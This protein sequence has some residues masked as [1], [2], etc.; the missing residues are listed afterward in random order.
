MSDEQRWKAKYLESLEQQEVFEHRWEKRLDLLRR[1]LVRSSLAAEGTDKAVDQCM[2]ELRN[3]VR[4]DDMDAALSALI[5]RLE[6]AVLDSEQRREQRAEQISQSLSALASRLQQLPLPREVNKPLKSYVRQLSSGAVHSSEL[7]AL[8]AELSRLQHDALEVIGQ[9]VVARPGLLQRL[10]GNSGAPAPAVPDAASSEPSVRP[11]DAALAP[12]SQEAATAPTQVI[13]P[14]LAPVDLHVHQKVAA[15]A[16]SPLSIEKSAPVATD[17]ERKGIEQSTELPLDSSYALPQPPE[18]GYSAVAPHIAASLNRLLDEL[19]LPEAHKP[20]AEGLRARLGEGLNWYELVPLLDDLAVLV[21]AVSGNNDHA[22]ARY[23]A[24]LNERLALFVSGL[25]QTQTDYSD[26]F[27][28]A[29]SLDDELREHV[30]N[31]QVSV[32]EA[33][34][35]E[36]LKQAVDKRLDGLLG[37][38]NEF[39]QRNDQR[40]RDVGERLQT[41]MARVAVMEQEAQGAQSHLEEQRLKA[42]TDALTG[43]PNRAAWTERVQIEHAR[44]Q[45]YGG[46]LLLV[47][48]DI[49]HFKRINDDYGHLAGDKVLKIIAQELQRRLRKTDFIARFGGEEFVLLLPSTPL[50]AGL[51]L[52]NDLR[53]KIAACPFHFKGQP[54][55]ITFSAG[56]VALQEG[57]SIDEAF[58]RADQALYRAKR[59]GRD[60]VERG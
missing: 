42:L 5:P 57:N 8:L 55:S 19:E 9:D 58:E 29:R 47:V 7:P 27:S 14:V 15:E 12:D 46:D 24:Q 17:A 25:N 50:E 33:Q 51:D 53:G 23:L 10:F 44:W 40:E 35:L 11:P 48:L 32:Q 21:L 41:L 13:E 16:P 59:S 28:D 60:R 4:G 31:L 54:V 20:Q 18:P 37:T 26:S 6:R 22:F 30:A 39:Q 36:T 45:R 49:D 3:V 56:A 38:M 43:L 1:G 52:L 2:K 34:D